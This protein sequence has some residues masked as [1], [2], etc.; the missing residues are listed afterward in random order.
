VENAF[1]LDGWAHGVVPSSPTEVETI[2]KRSCT[3]EA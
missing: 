3:D 1:L 2:E